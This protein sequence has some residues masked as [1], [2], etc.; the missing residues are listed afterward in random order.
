MNKPKIKT[1]NMTSFILSICRAFIAQY[2]DVI[3]HQEPIRTRGVYPCHK[4]CVNIP[5]INLHYENIY[6]F[7]LVFPYVLTSKLPGFSLHRYSDVLHGDMASPEYSAEELNYYRICHVA[8]DIILEGLRAIFKQEWDRLHLTT[9]GEWKDTPQNGQYF[10]KSESLRNRTR[11][12]RLLTTMIKGNRADW[13][14]TMLCYAILYSDCIHGLHSTVRASVDDLRKFRNEDFAHMSR[15]ALKDSN[16]KT[17]IHKVEVAFQ[18]LGLPTTQI[19]LIRNQTN[20]P[21]EEVNTLMKKVME[22]VNE[23]Q[24]LE[25]Q[26]QKEAQS[27]CVLPPAPSHSGTSRDKEVEETLQKLDQMK[28]S[29]KAYCTAMYISGN[30]GSGK[31]QLARQIGEKWHSGVKEHENTDAFVMTLNAENSDTLLESYIA[32]ARRLNCSEYAVTN[33]VSSTTSTTEDKIRSLK[34]LITRNLHLYTTWLLVV[35]NVIDLKLPHLPFPGS[36]EWKGG[37]LLITTQ[38]TSSIPPSNPF[39]LHVS[40][41]R[42]MEP[43]D[44]VRLLNSVSGITD[45]EMGETVARE[46]DYQPLALASA[47]TYVKLLRESGASPDFGWK[48]YLEK[49][50]EGKRQLTEE[51]LARTNPS[52]PISM[53]ATLTLTLKR[54]A[55]DEV[56]MKRAFDLICLCS[57]EPLPLEI[58]TNFIC[59]FNEDQERA[60]IMIKLQ[61]CPLFLF[62]YREEGICIRL[63]QIVHDV[64]TTVFCTS[65]GVNRQHFVYKTFLSFDR[66]V[67]T[68]L[69]KNTDS[70]VFFVKSKSL[71]PHLEVLVKELNHLTSEKGSSDS[72]HEHTCK[73][74]NSFTI[75]GKIC[76]RHCHLWTGLQYLNFLKNVSDSLNVT[77]MPPLLNGIGNL[78]RVLGNLQQAKEHHERALAMDLKHLDPEHVDVARCYV[79]LGN[80]YC[81]LGDLQQAKEHH[82]RALAIYLK[83]LDP[84]HVDVARCYTNLGIVY[85]ELGDLQQAKEHHKRALAIYMKHLDPEH[86]DVASCYVNLGNVYHELGNLQRAKEH[87]EHA[88]AIYM[89]HLDPEHVNVASCYTNLGAVHV[90]LGDLQQAKEHLEHALAIYLKHLDPEHVDVADCYVNLGIVYHKLGDLQQAKE[91]LELALAFYQKHLDLEHV[92]VACCC[93]NLGN[94]HRKLGDLQQAKQHLERAL[95]TFLKQLGPE[96]TNVGICYKDLGSV[97]RAMND[98]KQAKEHHQRAS[99]IRRLN[100]K[101]H[102]NA[103]NAHSSNTT[104]YIVL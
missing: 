43:A 10:Y 28:E 34:S 38:D 29:N 81:E 63:H 101:R 35:D 100:Q 1:I 79:N 60:E 94:V 71:V 23:K 87:Y 73:P 40:K 65:A 37:Q 16:F 22:L 30:P 7:I 83:H 8:T 58:M 91:H 57:K 66:Y 98:L 14:C 68:N 97:Y 42:G 67:T 26:L 52:Y 33:T 64:I 90:K 27:F 50:N 56:I 89:K 78:Y 70:D 76:E 6:C 55:Q 103:N 44:A 20:F 24:V 19:Q 74:S 62:E 75:F 21:T 41:S 61:Q 69:G 13:D 82:K 77:E 104:W 102:G 93:A 48:G 88:L 53:T 86:V 85:R 15:G 47:A 84:E 95:A 72:M 36:E 39:V 96:H 51:H 92:D 4:M 9:F 49:L 31:S 80:V 46:L 45:Q 12:A 11:N 59:D 54:S 99:T 3:K 18:A 5:L 17:A 25:D 2:N 32:F